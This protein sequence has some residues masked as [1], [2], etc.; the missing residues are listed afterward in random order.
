VLD[1]RFTLPSELN[2]PEKAHANVR[3]QPSALSPYSLRSNR[4]IFVFGILKRE[5]TESTESEVT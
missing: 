2:L 5:G 3:N 4:T 1:P